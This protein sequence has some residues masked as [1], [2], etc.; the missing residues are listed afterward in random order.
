MKQVDRLVSLDK[1]M[2]C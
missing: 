2:R 1:W